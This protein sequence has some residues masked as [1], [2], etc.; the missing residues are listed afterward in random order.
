MFCPQCGTRNFDNARFCVNCGAA[1][2]LPS[3]IS[4]AAAKKAARKSFSLKKFISVTLFLAVAVTAG[5]WVYQKMNE[6]D[7]DIIERRLQTFAT[8]YSDGDFDKLVSCFDPKTK[9]LL[10][11]TAGI[12]SKLLGLNVADLF[13]LLM[14]V[15]PRLTPEDTTIEI[16]VHKITFTSDTEAEADIT[17]RFGEQKDS[18]TLDM[19]KKGWN[20]YIDMSKSSF[21]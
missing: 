7:E 11:S 21:F 5:V 20:W 8:A 18:I 12:G 9:I 2:C 17:F 14:T 1:V 3:A 16:T 15:A 4:S 10:K 6:S 13:G 19:I